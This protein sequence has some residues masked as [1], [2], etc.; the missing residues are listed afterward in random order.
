MSI[1][2][3]YYDWNLVYSFSAYDSEGERIF[4]ENIIGSEVEEF[5]D[6]CKL[7]Y[8]NDITFIITPLFRNLY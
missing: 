3:Q 6:D 4:T 5:I 2:N 8:G 1:P 7:E